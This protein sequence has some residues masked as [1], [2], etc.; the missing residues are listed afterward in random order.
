MPRKYSKYSQKVV[1]YAKELWL[2]F[3]HN[4]EHR[5]KSSE[6]AKKIGTKFKKKITTKTIANWARE[7]EWQKLFEV[8]K[9]EGIKTAIV[10]YQSERQEL[11]KEKS[12]K[13]AGLYRRA[14][15]QYET[16][17]DVIDLWLEMKLAKFKRLKS[18]EKKEELLDEILVSA[19]ILNKKTFDILKVFI[20][21]AE[22][23][24]TMMNFFFGDTNNITNNNQVTNV[25]LSIQDKE[26]I[27]DQYG[28]A[29]E[30]FKLR[31]L[32]GG[33]GAK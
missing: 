20:P 21:D 29:Q 16:T 13:F 19:S 4:G 25:E 17:A 14:L 6:I 23:E 5:Y 8:A 22:S 31:S 3:D 32:K 30:M 7:H 33:K 26:R 15:K 28:M 10:E 9:Q 24:K 1:D 2:E 18:K 27:A 12:L 11:I